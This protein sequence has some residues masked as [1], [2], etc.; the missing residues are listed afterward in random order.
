MRWCPGQGSCAAGARPCAALAEAVA[1]E[2]AE[3]AAP[4]PAGLAAPGAAVAA[5][6]V[7][8]LWHPATVRTV[9]AGKAL[10]HFDSYTNRRAPPARLLLADASCSPSPS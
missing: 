7:L 8:G 9:R 6:S 10:V 4:A 1:Q 5:E 3:R 2:E